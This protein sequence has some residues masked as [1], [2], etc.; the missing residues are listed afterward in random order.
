MGHA[1]K[2]RLTG[3]FCVTAEIDR[4]HGRGQRL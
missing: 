1:T 3:D 2:E 4:C